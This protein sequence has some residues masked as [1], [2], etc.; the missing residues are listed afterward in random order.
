MKIIS[1]LFFVA[2]ATC[3][4][5]KSDRLK[6]SRLNELRGYIELL[7]FI[8]CELNTDI[9]LKIIFSNAAMVCSDSAGETAKALHTALKSENYASMKELWKN[10]IVINC[11]LPE[12][13]R[14]T[15]CEAGAVIGKY[16]SL[17]QAVC[18]GSIIDRL[19]KT[20]II[21]EADYTGKRKLSIFMPPLLTLI[22]ILAVL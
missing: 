6:R 11:S 12:N 5:I 16:D 7:K 17:V 2:A 15:L 9:P 22:A 1:C 3:A 13:E 14:Q 18:L 4:G 20:L 10:T 19:E 8:R 21:K